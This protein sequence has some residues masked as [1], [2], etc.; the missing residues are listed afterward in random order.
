MEQKPD[1]K[2]RLL[3]HREGADKG[4]AWK[5]VL[6]IGGGMVFL[7]LGIIGFFLPILQGFLFTLIGLTL[8]S[9]ES[10]R[11]RRL[12]YWLR[13]RT[14]I[15]EPAAAEPA[16]PGDAPAGEPGVGASRPHDERPGG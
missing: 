14:E 1:W 6:R 7:V 10:R 11:V 5:R 8:L 2:T 4:P 12:L 13:G 16:V 9:R 3:E 15:E